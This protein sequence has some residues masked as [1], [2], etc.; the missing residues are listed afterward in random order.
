MKKFIAAIVLLLNSCLYANSFGTWTM[1]WQMNENANIEVN[2]TTSSMTDFFSD[3]MASTA[4]W[5]DDSHFFQ[6]G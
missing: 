5:D 4:E 6:Q 3:Y 2:G 1:Y